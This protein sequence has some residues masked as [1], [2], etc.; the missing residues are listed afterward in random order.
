MFPPISP[1]FTIIISL[2]TLIYTYLP[3][4]NIIYIIC[5]HQFLYLPQ[6]LY[7]FHYYLR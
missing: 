5:L 3:L 4:F 6:Y 2:F 7:L 1:I